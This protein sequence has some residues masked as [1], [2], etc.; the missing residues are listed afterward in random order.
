MWLSKDCKAGKER[1]R[2]NYTCDIRNK[3]KRSIKE[4]EKQGNEDRRQ[5]F[6]EAHVD[7]LYISNRKLKVDICL[8]TMFKRSSQFLP[9]LSGRRQRK[10]VISQPSSVLSLRLKKKKKKK[11]RGIQFHVSSWQLPSTAYYHSPVCLLSADNVPELWCAL[12]SF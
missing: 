10:T 8:H 3:G 5:R 9:L 1:G 2:K 7:G 12:E 6:K 11:K 4:A